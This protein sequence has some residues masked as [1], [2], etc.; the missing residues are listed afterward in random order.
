MICHIFVGTAAHDGI[1][2]MHDQDRR[3]LQGGGAVDSQNFVGGLYH[4][5]RQFNARMLGFAPLCANL[6]LELFAVHILD[7]PYQ[8]AK[9]SLLVIIQG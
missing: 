6:A 8:A 9:V 3:R 4:L 2:A 1:A 7:E 5:M